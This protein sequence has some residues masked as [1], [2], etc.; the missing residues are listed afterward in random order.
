MK[1][2]SEL[3]VTLRKGDALEILKK[4]RPNSVDLIITDPPYLKEHIPLYAKIGQRAKRVLKPGAALVAYTGAY[5]LPEII[6]RLG[7]SLDW[8]WLTAVLHHGGGTTMLIERRIN[9]MYKPVL[10]F[11]KGKAPISPIMNDVIRGSGVSK[12]YHPWQQGIDELYP[13]IRKFSKPGGLIL[14]PFMGSGTTG[15]AALRMQRSFLGIEIDPQFF[16]IAKK[17]IQTARSQERLDFHIEGLDSYGGDPIEA[18]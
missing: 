17:R 15:I 13:F 11:T 1:F 14:D 2:P 6:S 3:K 5:H 12:S 4:L 8:Y 16:R 18:R 7:L 10:V 9:V